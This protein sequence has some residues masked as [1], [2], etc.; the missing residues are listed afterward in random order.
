MALKH[1]RAYELARETYHEAR[2]VEN[3]SGPQ[4]AFDIIRLV[5][6]GTVDEDRAD[7][8]WQDG[9][10]SGTGRA[11][12]RARHCDPVS[13]LD[14]NSEICSQTIGGADVC[15]EFTHPEAAPRNIEQVIGLH[16]PLVVGTTGWY[17]NLPT[18][19]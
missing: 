14:G 1:C 6:R 5:S 9:K 19:K 3:I 18:I 12:E 8:L 16:K 4:S 13:E 17:Q 2:F 7:W 11:E 10:R 15:V